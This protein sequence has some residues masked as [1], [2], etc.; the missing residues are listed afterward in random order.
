MSLLPKIESLKRSGNGFYQRSCHKDTSRGDRMMLLRLACVEYGKGLEEIL[1]YEEE[2]ELNLGEDSPE[3]DKL[4]VYKQQYYLN[5][6]MMNFFLNDSYECQKCCN[7]SLLFCNHYD[8]LL[9]DLVNQQDKIK[10][11][12]PILKPV[13]SRSHG[14]S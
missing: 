4:L 3:N 1:K 9:S 13:V 8:L 7:I 6:G 11:L 5:L 2:Y 10:N 14:L 12:I